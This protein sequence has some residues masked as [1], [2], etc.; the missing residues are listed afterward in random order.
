MPTSIAGGHLVFGLSAAHSDA[1]MKTFATLALAVVV[2]QAA[3]AQTLPTRKAGLWEVS[4]RPEGAADTAVLKVLQCTDRATDALTLMSIAP[5]QENCGKPGVARLKEKGHRIRT[6]CHVHEQRVDTV[7]ELKGDLMS[8]YEGRL[9]TRY[10]S[11]V[12]Q[13]PPPKVFEGR[14]LGE[15]R[16]GM[17]PGDMLLPNGVTVNV[18][19]DRRRA[20]ER[21]DHHDHK[22]HKH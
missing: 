7:M 20:E 6:A 17:R 19:D 5:G 11:M 13:T 4:I 22:G 10:P 1:S 15:C 14:W 12:S 2:N 9:E 3:W 16:A 8:R 21:Q 18:V